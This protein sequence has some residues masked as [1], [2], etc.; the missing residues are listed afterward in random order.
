MNIFDLLESPGMGRPRDTN[1]IQSA[2]DQSAASV[3]GSGTT[4]HEAKKK[5]VRMM[6][7]NVKESVEEAAVKPN[8]KMPPE[9]LQDKM[10]RQHQELR[11]KRGAPSAEEYKQRIAQKQKEIDDLKEGILDRAAPKMPKPRNP[12][13]AVLGNKVNASGRHL[14]KKRRQELAPKHKHQD[15]LEE[16][17]KDAVAGAAL[18]GSIALGGVAHAGEPVVG[19]G[20]S[21]NMQMAVDMA[22]HNA[23][24]KYLKTV[25][26]DNFQDKQMP[27]H[28]YG[29]LELKPNDKGGYIATVPLIV[30]T[31]TQNESLRP[32]ERHHF[33]TDPV[34][35]KRVYKGIRGDQQD[36]PQRAKDDPA[37]RA[38]QERKAHIA[39]DR[40]LTEQAVEE[41]FRLG[42]KLGTR[43]DRFKSLRKRKEGILGEVDVA[44]SQAVK[45]TDYDTWSDE[46]KALG[47]EI[48][49]QKDRNV[50]VAQSWDGE[51]IGKF[52]LGKSMGFI[53]QQGVAEGKPENPGRRGFLKALAV[54]AVLSSTPVAKLMSDASSKM[55]I[56]KHRGKLG[57]Y[58]GSDIDCTGYKIGKKQFYITVDGKP[59]TVQTG[60]GAGFM[61]QDFKNLDFKSDT[62]L[63]KIAPWLDT[64]DE[65]I[66]QI[67][68]YDIELYDQNNQK[69]FPAKDQQQTKEMYSN[70]FIDAIIGY[71]DVYQ[72]S[73]IQQMANAPSKPHY[74]KELPAIDKGSKGVSAI[75]SKAA[76]NDPLHIARLTS[77]AK[78]G[79]DAITKKPDAQQSAPKAA[80]AAL[81]APSDDN[82]LRPELNK[83]KE[84]S[85]VNRRGVEE[86]VAEGWKG[87]LA[88]AALAG[89]A[90]LGG[91][92]V[93]AQN[94]NLPGPQVS[95]V[96]HVTAEANGREVHR[97]VNLGSNYSS[98]QEAYDDIESSLQA[99][100]IT[101]Y[102]INIEQRYDTQYY[103]GG[104][105][106]RGGTAT[107]REYATPG[108][109]DMVIKHI[110]R[111]I[112]AGIPSK[113]GYATGGTN[114]GQRPRDGSQ[115]WRDQLPQI[116]KEDV[117]AE[118]IE[119][120]LYLMSRAGYDIVQEA[121]SDKYK[122]SINCSDPK[123]FSQKAHCAGKKKNKS[124]SE[125]VATPPAQ[126]TDPYQQK[127]LDR[128]GARFGLQPGATMDQV[129]AAQQA[130]LDKNDPA[131]AA[132][133]KQ[134][135]T[136]IDTGNTAANKP[137]QLAPKTPDPDTTAALAAGKANKSPTAIMLSQPSIGQNQAMLD[138]IAP[139]LGLPVGSSLEQLLAADDARHAKGGGKYAP[140]S[141]PVGED[142]NQAVDSKGRTQQQWMQL[143]KDKFPDAKIIQ[144]K[145]INGPCQAIL[146]D[147]RKLSWSKV[148]EDVAEEKVRL[149]PKCWTGKKIG[150]P[151]TK[152]KGGVRVNNCV[153]K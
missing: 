21:Q 48:H 20:Q 64:K 36:A 53:N 12:A 84:K 149:D 117:L 38:D 61:G 127:L 1:G 105:Q 55:S 146:S 4:K 112:R 143:V 27:D 100:G 103:P 58:Q 131:A 86:D 71:L 91:G 115:W 116:M 93:D 124:V 126:T 35:G 13:N 66:L 57:K 56:V 49:P 97:T 150:N 52:H 69:I 73:A 140:S 108:I 22:K 28:R 72:T 47:G 46:V 88:G 83:Q 139:T 101:R 76:G 3:I 153:P 102:N 31:E 60:T 79:Y 90:A 121:W 148:K 125:A 107:G 77:L 2:A 94:I 147:G 23:R 98:E 89:A 43:R 34:T 144:S 8:F 123:G 118:E 37:A 59:Y 6:G 42:K 33:E 85:P 68:D 142:M 29:K 132:Q 10:Y 65:Y 104:N 92:D 45:I 17:W 25:H 26:G 62:Y 44:E 119:S 24:V 41:E 63:Q 74:P 122:R 30:D 99:K 15:P 75:A 120:H 96:A 5:P 134:N 109:G 11:N 19:M 54:A 16:G 81:P 137:V 80:P 130:Y 18:A 82:V 87:K 9:S 78:S 152:M 141:Q 114:K 14:D 110:G 133:Y 39:H 128:M 136:N 138:V 67:A 129:Q 7:A 106:P 51:E 50:L 40:G 95:Y 135:M 32:G 113:G 145:M 111:E 151:K 70:G